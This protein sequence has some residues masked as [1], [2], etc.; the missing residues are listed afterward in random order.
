MNNIID[1]IENNNYK[2]KSIV[3]DKYIFV[4]KEN[5]CE[6][7]RIYFK[8]G[9]YNVSFPM[10]NNNYNYKTHFTSESECREY[11]RQILEYLFY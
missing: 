11:V 6:E 4:N 9:L 5:D 7:I 3:S 10:K 1:I 8:D 2:A